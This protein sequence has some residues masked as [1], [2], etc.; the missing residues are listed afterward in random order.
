VSD[1]W[2]G[3][4]VDSKLNRIK[5]LQ[6]SSNNLCGKFSK[7]FQPLCGIAGKLTILD[8]RCNLISGEIPSAIGY[9]SSLVEVY[10]RWGYMQNLLFL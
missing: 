6:L 7:C 3:V 9:L 8:L 5:S 4:T 1:D 2:F 10:L